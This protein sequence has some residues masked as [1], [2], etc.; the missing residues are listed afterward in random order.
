MHAADAPGGDGGG[1]GGGGGGGT[2]GGLG[3][4]G[5]PLPGSKLALYRVGHGMQALQI[6]K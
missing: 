3:H 6:A 2:G 5:Q 4:A 1:G